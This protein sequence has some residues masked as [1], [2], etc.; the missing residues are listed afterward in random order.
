MRTNDNYEP[1]SRT[2]RLKRLLIAWG[3]LALGV[4]IGFLMTWNAFFVYV[5]PG[6]HLVIISKDGEPLPNND[7]AYQPV[8]AGSGQKDTQK[9]LKS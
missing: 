5:P 2:L 1:V 3:V 4:L 9:A 8:H 6:K 7:P